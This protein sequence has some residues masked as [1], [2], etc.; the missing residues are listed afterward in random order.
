M[1]VRVF[2]PGA[3]AGALPVHDPSPAGPGAVGPLG[4]GGPLAVDGPGTVL[5]IFNTLTPPA[6]LQ[7]RGGRKD[8][9]SS[10]LIHTG[11][12]HPDSL[13]TAKHTQTLSRS[14]DTSPPRIFICGRGAA[15]G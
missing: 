10:F 5:P 11:S 12:A 8:T 4:P 15:G 14:T 6:P 9:F 7:Q 3:G 1:C 13:A 2:L